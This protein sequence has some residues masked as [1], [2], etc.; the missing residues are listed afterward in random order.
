MTIS[1]RTEKNDLLYSNE[2]LNRKKQGVFIDEYMIWRKVQVYTSWVDWSTSPHKGTTFTEGTPDKSRH[3]KN[4]GNIILN[5]QS[6]NVSIWRKDSLIWT[7][8]WAIINHKHLKMKNV[9]TS[10]F[11]GKDSSILVQN[12]GLF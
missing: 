7:V 9:A 11:F 2:W 12:N 6:I 1:C 4:K 5:S 3:E 10:F 8:I